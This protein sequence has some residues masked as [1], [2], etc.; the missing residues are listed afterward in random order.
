[1]RKKERK[2]QMIINNK[3]YIYLEQ[4]QLVK[5]TEQ[6]RII[7]IGKKFL[8]NRLVLLDGHSEISTYKLLRSNLRMENDFEK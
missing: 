4:V 8:P 1:M 5:M 2:E 7:E 6:A 3:W